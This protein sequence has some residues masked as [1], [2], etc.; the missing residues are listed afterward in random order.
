[1][2]EQSNLNGTNGK[3]SRDS[4]QRRAGFPSVILPLPVIVAVVRL[5]GHGR[6]K[7]ISSPASHGANKLNLS[8]DIS[9]KV[10]GFLFPV[11]FNRGVGMTIKEIAAI[12]R[13]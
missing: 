11:P 7:L 13:K 3:R 12:R 5:T 6:T 10:T 4:D 8:I 9:A 1:M 2:N